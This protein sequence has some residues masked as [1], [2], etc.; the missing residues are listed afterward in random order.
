[1]EKREFYVVVEQDEDGY[2]VGEVTQ[3]TACYSQGE[4]IEELIGNMREVICLCLENEDRDAD[5]I[6]EF[7]G[8]QRIVV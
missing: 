3:L 7:V 1:M 4:T 5:V 8:V 2:F 6:P